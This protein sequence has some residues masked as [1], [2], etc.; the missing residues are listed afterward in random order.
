[1]IAQL[2]AHPK[3]H[4][5]AHL[6]INQMKISEWKLQYL[7]WKNSLDGLSMRIEMTGEKSVGL[8]RDE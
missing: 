7:K 1:M 8:K 5:I 2:F 3:N 6:K 4:G